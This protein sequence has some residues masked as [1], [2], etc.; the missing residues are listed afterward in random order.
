MIVNTKT[1]LL[2]SGELIK[3]AETRQAGQRSVIKLHVRYG[4]DPPAEAGGRKSGKLLDVDVWS[5]IEA[6]D[7]MLCKGDAV[8]ISAQQVKSREYNGKTYYSVD[9]DGLYPSAAVVLRWMQQ[10]IDM[11]HA[12]AEGL[13]ATLEKYKPLLDRLDGFDSADGV[14]SPDGFAEQ[15]TPQQTEMDQP[16]QVQSAQPA[17]QIPPVPSGRAR[18]AENAQ[19]ETPGS[20]AGHELY[21]GEQISDYAP[22]WD[23]RRRI[24][25][26]NNTAAAEPTIDDAEDLPF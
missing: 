9:A 17:Q 12:E 23:A 19:A 21:D 11:T 4:Y 20:L 14:P 5:D 8:V 26:P 7:G 13:Y 15:L 24:P 2:I 16:T 6:L 22:P 3:D 25:V 10:V 1:G 18:D